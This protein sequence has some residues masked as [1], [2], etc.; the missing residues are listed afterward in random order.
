[1][2]HFDRLRPYPQTLDKAVKGCQGP[3]LAYYGNLQ[4]TA[5]ISFMI[6]APEQLSFPKVVF[7]LYMIKFK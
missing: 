7:T 5:I 3:T 1:V 4:I 6:Q 2:L